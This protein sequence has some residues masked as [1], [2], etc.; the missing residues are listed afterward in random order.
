MKN[1]AKIT[2]K[3]PSLLCTKVRIKIVNVAHV[4]KKFQ[5]RCYLLCGKPTRANFLHSLERRG[6]GWLMCCAHTGT[7][8]KPK[9]LHSFSKFIFTIF[10]ILDI[11]D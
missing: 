6:R 7:S 8:L 3:E 11:F 4:P 10:C 9:K 5:K 1:F 2:Q